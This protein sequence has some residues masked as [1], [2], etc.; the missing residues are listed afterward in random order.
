MHFHR[1]SNS[2]PPATTFHRDRHNNRFISKCYFWRFPQAPSQ[3]PSLGSSMLEPISGSKELLIVSSK[4]GV[5]HS[6]CNSPAWHCVFEYFIEDGWI[7]NLSS[8]LWHFVTS[9]FSNHSS[10]T[11]LSFPCSFSLRYV[12]TCVRR[13]CQTGK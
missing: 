6:F 9:S 4:S 1:L 2:N 8:E 13:S 12:R 11:P 7:P 5:H 3:E 10:T